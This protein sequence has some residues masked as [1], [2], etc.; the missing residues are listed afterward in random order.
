M[1]SF[2]VSKHEMDQIN[3]RCEKW[4][5]KITAI[6]DLK[7]A[8]VVDMIWNLTNTK[9]Y[10]PSLWQVQDLATYYVKNYQYITV[11]ADQNNNVKLIAMA[12]KENDLN[13]VYQF[14]ASEKFAWN[15]DN[16]KSIDYRHCD[17]CKARHDRKK[18]FIVE[19]NGEV[20][21]VGG[22]C[23]S[24]LDLEVH[25]SKLKSAIHGFSDDSEGACFEDFL[26]AGKWTPSISPEFY[27]T[28]IG[29]FTKNKYVSKNDAYLDYS[30]SSKDELNEMFEEKKFQEYADLG[31]KLLQENNISPDD[32]HQEIVNLFKQKAESA[33]EDKFTFLN[34]C[35]VSLIKNDDK[36]LGMI[37]WCCK[38]FLD[39]LNA[40]KCKDLPEV[41]KPLDLPASKT[42]D[43]PG[44]FY[45]KACKPISN[46]YGN[47]NYCI[48]VNNNGEGVS[49]KIKDVP[50]WLKPATEFKLR[51]GIKGLS[52]KGDL[53]A[54]ERAKVSKV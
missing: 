11:E 19:L 53:L 23:A 40:S 29:W 5:V 30:M 22:S 51:G 38:A 16:S 25:V 7:H 18:V 32:I 35:Y 37:V 43:L 14:A 17:R 26:M 9:D 48:A 45:L 8:S 28:A 20:A 34:N 10:C 2:L 41:I 52:W 39:D 46:E 3:K 12:E 24:S 44:T 42:I 49:F 4:K 33:S 47:T 54:V 31:V 27:H 15:Q 1:K 50:E 13:K 36:G 6:E 21:Q